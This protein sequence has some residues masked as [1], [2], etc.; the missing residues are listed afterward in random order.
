MLTD[1]LLTAGDY[2]AKATLPGDP[3]SYTLTVP[4]GWSGFS[5]W[6]ITGSGGDRRDRDRHRLPA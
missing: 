1:G 2:V 3:L 6:A 5:T 4:A